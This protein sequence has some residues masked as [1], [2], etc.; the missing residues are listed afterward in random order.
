MKI[1]AVLIK[2]ILTEKATNMT[3]KQVYMFEVNT[4]VSKFQVKETLEKFK[5]LLYCHAGKC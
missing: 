5:I 1:D 3:K 2:P 4:A